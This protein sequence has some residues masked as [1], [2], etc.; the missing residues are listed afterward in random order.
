MKYYG[1]NELREK[2]LKFFESKEHLRKGSFSLVPSNDKSLLLINS[3]MAPLKPYFTGA[4]VPP[5]KRMTTCQ[6][7]IRTGDIENV[8]KTARHGTFFEMLGNFSFGDYFKEE[9]ISWAWEFFTKELEIP[10]E[11]LYVSVYEDD[12]EAAKIWHEQE[13]VPKERIVYMGKEDNFWEHGVGPCGP[14]SEI[15]IDRGEKYGCGSHDCKVGCECDRFVEVWNLVFTQFELKESGEYVPLDFPNIDTG[16][17][18]ERLAVMMQGVDSIFDVDTIVAVEDKVCELSGEK[19]KVDDETDVSI[20]LITDHVRSITFMASDGIM[21]SNEG[22]G[23]VFRRLLRRASHHGK[24]I[25]IEGKFL[26]DLVDVVIETSK[27]AYSELEEKKEYIKSVISMEEDRFA[28]TID[29]GMNILLSHIK[30]LKENNKKVLDGEKVFVLHDTYGFP[31][32]LTRE[33]LEEKGMDI[34]LE[35]YKENMEIQRE[36]ARKARGVD[37]YMGNDGSVYDG[38]NISENTVFEG[39]EKLESSSEI[40][41]IITDEEVSAISA[42]QKGSV[43]VKNTPFYATSGGQIADTGLIK[44]ENAVFEVH[45]VKKLA[46]GIFAHIGEVKS[47]SFNL[48]D[49]VNLSVKESDRRKIM[50]N[51]SATHLLQQAL[52]DVLGKHVEQAGSSVNADRLRFDFTHF[53]SMTKEELEKAENIVNEK[54]MAALPVKYEVLPI[55]EAKKRGA[56]ALF[57]EKYG[58][59]VRVISMGNEKPY[60]VELCGGTHVSNT[61]A[62]GVFKLI[63]ESGIAAGVRRIEAITGQAVIDYYKQKEE[64]LTKVCKELKTDENSLILKVGQVLDENKSLRKVLDEI[65]AK[66]AIGEL[67]EI[68]KNGEEHGGVS[69]YKAR[70][71]LDFKSLEQLADNIIAKNENSFVVLCSADGG[72]VNLLSIASKNAVDKGIDCG[73][74]IRESAKLVGGGGGGRK[75]IARAGGKNEA[76]IESALDKAINIAKEMIN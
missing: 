51:H 39:Y 38:L 58:K 36:R 9:A 33:I 30:D 59:E 8:G 31:V 1:L 53:N 19:Y 70:L 48:G 5:K 42:G 24:K 60:S 29:N 25:G 16:M 6:K 56:M 76:G 4:E 34:D 49:K 46:G 44:N 64:L 18:L 41:S 20:R 55:E 11:L 2:F 61:S 26:T 67:D 17:G 71:D 35:G 27:G 72:K 15:Y 45:D 73:K 69:L 54:V 7:C 14:C 40:I 50:A 66:E 47:G 57:G 22:R 43:F 37:T 12:H 52:R 21:P 68:L 63:S 13:G 10:E 62:I 75:N 65:K 28:K 3:G 74:I 23:Y 32:D